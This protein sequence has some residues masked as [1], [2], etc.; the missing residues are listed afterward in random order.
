MF[1][2]I[3]ISTHCNFSCFYCAGRNL[4]QRHMDWALFQ[5]IM[6]AIPDGLHTVSL[7]G[8]G[9]PFSHPR[10]WDMVAVVHDRGMIPFTITN[11]SLLDPVR[12][13]RSFPRIGISLDTIDPAEAESIGRLNLQRIM[14]NL[15][16]LL[17]VMHPG[18]IQVFTVDF[19]QSL[20]PLQAFLRKRNLHIHWT[21]QK[22][23]TKDDY[24][25]RYPERVPRLS[26]R[27]SFRCRYLE[28]SRMRFY[29]IQGREYPCCY[30]KNPQSYLP[31]HK[32]KATMASR[33][34]PSC[35][36]GCREITTQSN[37]AD[38]IFS[39]AQT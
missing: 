28:Q 4:P 36:S 24:A 31:I 15:Q 20:R 22:L 29:D 17:T 27:I 23:Q 30:I 39:T 26:R 33:E 19:G 10:F 1:Y 11:G 2:Q 14:T 32:I 25:R 3:E 8:E 18:R 6:A 21:V 37:V 34:V 35:C 9:E 12:I 13:P 5:N 7:Q 38:P 16:N